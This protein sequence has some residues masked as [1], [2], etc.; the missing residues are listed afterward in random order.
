MD[1]SDKQNWQRRLEELEVEIDREAASNSQEQEEPVKPHVEI[2]NNNSSV[3]DWL[4][5]A[6]DWFNGLA[7]IGQVAVGIVGIMVGFSLLGALI[8]VVSSVISIAIVG[9]LVYIAYKYLFAES[10]SKT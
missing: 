8:K 9:G 7:P 4:N 5:A 3:L 1:S 10:S 2:A 6:R